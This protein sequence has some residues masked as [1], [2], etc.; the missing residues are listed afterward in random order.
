MQSD[1]RQLSLDPLLSP[2][3]NPIQ[4]PSS[5]NSLAPPTTVNVRSTVPIYQVQPTNVNPWTPYGHSFGLPQVPVNPV[6]LGQL[7]GSLPLVASH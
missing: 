1:P 2:E 4:L 7:V 3:I 5:R 6:Q